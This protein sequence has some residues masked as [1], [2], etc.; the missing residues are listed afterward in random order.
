MSSDWHS[1]CVSANDAPRLSLALSGRG[2]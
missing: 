2:C 1:D